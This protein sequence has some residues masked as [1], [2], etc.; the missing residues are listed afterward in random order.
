MVN[1]IVLV[2]RPPKSRTQVSSTVYHKES[3]PLLQRRWKK[4][5]ND[6]VI[7][8]DDYDLKLVPDIYDCIKYDA[9]QEWRF[10]R[11]LSGCILY[12][13][14]YDWPVQ[15]LKGNYHV[16][17]P[18]IMLEN[19][20]PLYNQSHFPA[21]NLSILF[22]KIRMM[23]EV[24][25]PQEYGISDK[26]KYDIAVGYCKPLMNK[27]KNDIGLVLSVYG[28]YATGIRPAYDRHTTGIRPAYDRHSVA[29]FQH[30]ADI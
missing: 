14:S 27:I 10:H 29:I 7:G 24:I 12:L 15:H 25:V 5:K 9:L 3:L 13:Y 17:W 19:I 1:Q 18:I 8:N 23:A 2:G 30:T 22:E 28:R 16:F 20:S 11:A 6:F 26:E 4:L 21:R